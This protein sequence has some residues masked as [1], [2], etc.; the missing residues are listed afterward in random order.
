MFGRSAPYN[1]TTEQ[2]EDFARWVTVKLYEARKRKHCYVILPNEFPYD[3][4]NGKEV[5]TKHLVVRYDIRDPQDYEQIRTIK[6][7]FRNQ[8]YTII[9][10]AKND[11]SIP[12]IEHYHAVKVI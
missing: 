3:I 5:K 9:E 12:H 10:H 6:D 7:N 1:S 8:G 2:K 4:Q 11:K